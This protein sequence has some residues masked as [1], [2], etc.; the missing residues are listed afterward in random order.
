MSFYYNKTYGHNFYKI[1]EIIFFI[2]NIVFAQF[3]K[4]AFIFIFKI[5]NSFI[6]NNEKS[7]L[8]AISSSESSNIRKFQMSN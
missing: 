8:K 3:D 7:Y 2:N 1:I 4:H 5:F 6:T